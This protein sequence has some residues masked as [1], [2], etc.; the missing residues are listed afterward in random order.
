VPLWANGGI[1]RARQ[2]MAREVPSHS[3]AKGARVVWLPHAPNH[4]RWRTPASLSTSQLTLLGDGVAN[5]SGVVGCTSSGFIK[6]SACL[7]R[8]GPR[9]SHALAAHS[10]ASSFPVWWL[11][12]CA[13]LNRDQTAGG[14]QLTAP[15]GGSSYRR[16]V[17]AR[18]RGGD[19]TKA[20]GVQGMVVFLLFS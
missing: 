12:T 4:R 17:G 18:D 15:P 14:L 10:T 11:Q 5:R 9:A 20:A 2:Q 6:R 7:R 3:H 16:A 8:I 19:A 13:S 1:L